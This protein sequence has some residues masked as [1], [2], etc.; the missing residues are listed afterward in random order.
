MN[1]IVRN[2]DRSSKVGGAAPSDRQSNSPPTATW[3]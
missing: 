3:S 1:V 2:P